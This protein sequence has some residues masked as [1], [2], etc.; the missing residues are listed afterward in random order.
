M[1]FF[2]LAENSIQLVPDG[3]LFLHIALILIMIYVLNRT[4]FRPINNILEERDKRTRGGSNEAH[5]LLKSV[6]EKLSLYER[7][8][9]QAREDGY[10]HLEGV[11][12]QALQERQAQI[13]QTREELTEAVRREKTALATQIQG[14]RLELENEAKRIAAEISRHILNRPSD[15]GATSGYGIN[16]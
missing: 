8:L 15:G 14:S 13:I 4:L 1:T 16:L 9:R 3:T 12:T 5:N 11:R 7:T 10:R 2:A 6:E